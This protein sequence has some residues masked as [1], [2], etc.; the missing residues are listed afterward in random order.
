MS[1]DTLQS[2]EESIRAGKALVDMNTALERLQSNRDFRKVIL[3]GYFQ[4][5]AVRLVHL[6][7]DPAFQTT[8]R[9][10]QIVGQIDAIGG[11]H[12]YFTTVKALASI[13]A[14]EV[15]ENEATREELLAEEVQ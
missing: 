11:L 10:A 12:S 15:A 6:K 8:E 13:A 2:I 14:K 9:Q 3:E 5:E 7:A 1:K 4:A